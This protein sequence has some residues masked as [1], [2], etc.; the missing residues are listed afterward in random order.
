MGNLLRKVLFV[1]LFLGTAIFFAGTCRGQIFQPQEPDV[2]GV[3]SAV[4]HYFQ[5]AVAAKNSGDEGFLLFNDSAI[6][7]ANNPYSKSAL[8]QAYIHRGKLLR[9]SNKKEQIIENYRLALDITRDLNEL[10]DIAYLYRLLGFVTYEEFG[11]YPLSINFYDTA[12]QIMDKEGVEDVTLLGGVYLNKGMTYE[13]MGRQD[14]VYSNFLKAFEVFEQAADTLGLVQSANN[15]ANY[16][17]KT[18]DITKAV[19]YF[20]Q[21]LRY[22]ENVLNT[23][24]KASISI[25]LSNLHIRTNN[26]SKA[27]R[28]YE[29]LLSLIPEINSVDLK[30]TIYHNYGALL[31]MMSRFEESVE[32]LHRGRVLRKTGGMEDDL[33]ASYYN[34]GMA[35][36]DWGKPDSQLFYYDKC[37]VLAQ[38]TSN[39]HS[40]YMANNAL[41][42]TFRA[43]GNKQKALYHILKANEIALQ[44]KDLKQIYQSHGEIAGFYNELGNH[45]KAYDYHVLY[46]THKDS[47]L[48]EQSQNKIA[49][50]NTKF[51]TERKEREI[52]ILTQ[53][54]ALRDLR[55]QNQET[56]MLRKAE[57]NKLFITTAVMIVLMLIIFGILYRQ[58]F[59]ALYLAKITSNELKAL[60]A[61][62]NPHFIFNALS[63]VQFYISENQKEK[64]GYYLSSFSKLTRRILSQSENERISLADEIETLNLF[65]ELECVRMKNGFDYEVTIDNRID[66]DNTEI[67]SM[68]IQPLAENAVW[69]GVSNAREKGKIKIHFSRKNEELRISVTDNGRGLDNEKTDKPKSRGIKITQDRIARFNKKNAKHPLLK[70]TNLSPGLRVEFSIPFREIF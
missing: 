8:A 22:G 3:D 5:K 4:Q 19:T 37:R 65:L 18:G 56:E 66:P 24:Q 52:E 70:F 27:A 67:P 10:R 1:F 63:S 7:A 28:V 6:E 33:T 60:R 43:G 48:D 39:Q 32:M 20:Q 50:L 35:F 53:E 13:K 59:K 25:N 9:L 11:D 15:L 45:K 34:L 17:H 47:F 23:G 69:H 55:I 58:R 26:H 21:A 54:N 68:L 30:A 38:K 61:Q 29:E 44:S 14:S 49:E 46:T 12:I 40:L 62:M 2:A 57:Q 42:K 31:S 41:F 64:A 51:E 16:Y 36:E